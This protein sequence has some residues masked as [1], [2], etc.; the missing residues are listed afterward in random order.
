MD[1]LVNDQSIHGQFREK[2]VF[3]EALAR[4]MA[5]RHLAQ[6]FGWKVYCHRALLIAKP[7]TNT[8]M[9]EALGQLTMMNASRWVADAPPRSILET[10]LAF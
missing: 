10:A 3:R 6:R 1:L 5:M 7:M 9:Q 4:L 2:A 8:T